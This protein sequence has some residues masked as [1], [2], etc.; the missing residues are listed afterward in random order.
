M[1]T[2]DTATLAAIKLLTTACADNRSMEQRRHDHD[3]L[4]VQRKEAERLKKKEKQWKEEQ[5]RLAEKQAEEEAGA[6]RSQLMQANLGP[7]PSRP[8]THVWL[9]I[10]SDAQS[11]DRWKQKFAALT[12][13]FL[14]GQTLF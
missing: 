10:H 11:N 13:V 8:G 3:K 4:A 2:Q 12:V 14:S 1:Q 7:T 9:P 6:V 5:K